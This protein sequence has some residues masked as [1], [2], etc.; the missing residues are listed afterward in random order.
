[1]FIPERKQK[2]HPLGIFVQPPLPFFQDLLLLSFT[3]PH[4]V[5]QSSQQ[6][7]LFIRYVF[8]I[9]GPTIVIGTSELF[10]F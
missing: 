3:Y 4:Y 6:Q 9:P 1:M 10:V 7:E 2:P 5:S 8:E